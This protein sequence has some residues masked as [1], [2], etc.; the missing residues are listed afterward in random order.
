LQKT[1]GSIVAIDGDR[2][3]KE[4]KSTLAEVLRDSA[5]VQLMGTG[6]SG[7]GFFVS[8]RGLCPVFG[9]DS[10]VTI[11]LNG[12]FQQRAQSTRALFTTSPASKWSKAPIPR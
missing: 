3:A 6:A 1:A 10:P 2:M 7:Q 8:I 9:Q 4:G 12:V 5:G 11:S